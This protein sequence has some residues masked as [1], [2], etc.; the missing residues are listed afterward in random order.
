MAV[1]LIRVERNMEAMNVQLNWRAIFAGAF[2]TL[3]FGL[4]FLL[5][6]NAIGLNAANTVRTDIGAALKTWS[7]IYMAATLIFSYFAGAFLSTRSI[8][9]D[10]PSSGVLHGLTSWGLASAII[11]IGGSI[12]SIGF[13]ALLVGFAS[14][15]ANWLSVCVIGL[16]AVGAAA[17]GVLGKYSKHEFGVRT[18]GVTTRRAA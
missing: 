5:L 16:G 8:E 6:G 3:G 10:T 12:A 14:N 2:L 13:R 11:A 18:E 15:S 7:W 17:G 9:V 1:K 4:F